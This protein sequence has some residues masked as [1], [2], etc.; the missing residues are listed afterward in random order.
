MG[1]PFSE[2]DNEWDAEDT[3]VVKFIQEMIEVGTTDGFTHDDWPLP[4][5]ESTLA[6]KVTYTE[7]EP[8]NPQIY[9]A[10]AFTLKFNT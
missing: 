1:H 10:L 9:V 2:G 5:D 6:P 4:N 7:T 8:I 3:S